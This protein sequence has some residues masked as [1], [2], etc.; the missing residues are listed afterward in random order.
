M[1][2]GN[3]IIWPLDGPESA[4]ATKGS[5]DG[6]DEVCMSVINPVENG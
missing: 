3:C 5:I 2:F 4:A 1:M 6:P